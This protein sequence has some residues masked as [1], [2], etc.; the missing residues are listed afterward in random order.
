MTFPTPL[1]PKP[2][3]TNWPAPVDTLMIKGPG[4]N[5]PAIS[6]CPGENNWI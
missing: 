3:E 1:P 6:R 5:F 2:W 4:C